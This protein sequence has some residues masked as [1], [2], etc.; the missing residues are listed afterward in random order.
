[1]PSTTAIKLTEI[2]HPPVKTVCDSVTNNID[3]IMQ[4]NAHIDHVKRLYYA[5]LPELNPSRV[6][7]IG[8]GVDFK[9]PD[10]R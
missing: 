4:K 6:V 9:L 8:P 5:G 1:M 10:R 7:P 2:A 3:A